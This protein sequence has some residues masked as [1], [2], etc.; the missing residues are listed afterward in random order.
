MSARAN[1]TPTAD[2]WR[3]ILE[4]HARWLRS[5]AGGSRA[6]LSRANTGRAVKACPDTQAARRVRFPSLGEGVTWCASPAFA[7]ARLAGS[8]PAR[9]TILRF[10]WN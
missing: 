4:K 7:L 10:G 6:N 2:E 3:E 8:T 9:S 5:E 1:K